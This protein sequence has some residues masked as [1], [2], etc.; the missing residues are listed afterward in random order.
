LCFRHR[1]SHFG[2]ADVGTSVSGRSAAVDNIKDNDVDFGLWD[3]FFDLALP[4]SNLFVTADL[5]VNDVVPLPGALPLFATGLRASGSAWLAQET[6]ERRCY[7]CLIK[8]PASSAVR[9]LGKFPLMSQWRIPRQIYLLH[10]FLFPLLRHYWS[11]LVGCSAI[12]VLDNFPPI[13]QWRI[14][15]QIYLP[16]YLLFQL[17]R[18]YWSHYLVGC[19][20]V[21]ALDTFPPISRW[22]IHQHILDLLHYLLF[23]LNRVLYRWHYLVGC[24]FVRVYDRFPPMSQW[25]IHQHILYL[26]HYL[27]FQLLRQQILYRSHYLEFF[28]FHNSAAASNLPWRALFASCYCANFRRP[29]ALARYCYASLHLH[30]GLAMCTPE[31]GCQAQCSRAARK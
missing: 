1:H 21:R 16:H 14:H 8:T 27:L 26:L 13:S 9:V 4:T 23:H 10:Y 5:R 18:H 24:T 6:E 7:R 22:R 31:A 15:Q 30:A 11:H 19:N 20:A 2:D 28:V 12:H 25:R 17:L 29:V 3:A